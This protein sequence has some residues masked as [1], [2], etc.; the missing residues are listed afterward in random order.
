MLSNTVEAE[1]AIIFVNSEKKFQE[2]KD[3]NFLLQLGQFFENVG[4]PS[5]IFMMSLDG[6]LEFWNLASA[7]SLQK[8]IE[9]FE[10]R[11]NQGMQDIFIELKWNV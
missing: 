3:A 11:S 7:E 1:R 10:V 5:D 9:P 2:G 6:L 8:S 4:E